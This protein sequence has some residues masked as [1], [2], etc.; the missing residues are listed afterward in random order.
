MASVSEI[1]VR[2]YLETLGFLVRQPTKYQVTARAK[3]PEEEIDLVAVNPT[4]AGAPP[5]NGLPWGGAELRCV[6]R[7]I[8]S[9]RGWHT[10]RITPAILDDAPEMFRIAADEV[11]RAA[12]PWIGPGPIARVLCLP[13]LPASRDLREA[14]LRRLAERGVD[15]V[16]TF[17]TVLS[18]LAA[19]VDANSNYEKSDLLQMLRIL[20]NYGLLRDAQLDLFNGRARRFLK[21]KERRPRP[22][23]NARNAD[24]SAGGAP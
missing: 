15:G 21:P 20:K 12:E 22:P 19:T 4:A 2:D 17:R 24:E 6:R 5:R 13:A 11:A 10:E 23:E 16:L 7:A 1:I 9:V 8:F 14:T 18:E 3:R